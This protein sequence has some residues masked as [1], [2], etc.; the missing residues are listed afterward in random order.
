MNFIL[1]ALCLSLTLDGVLSECPNINDIPV[2]NA[3][4]DR[5]FCAWFWQDKGNPEPIDSCNGGNGP[6]MD[7]Y[8]FDSPSGSYMPMES[9][10]VKAGCTL[11]GYEGHA[12]TKDL[13]KFY[14]PATYPEPCT[15]GECAH[16]LGPIFGLRGF[17]SYRC[18]C[19]QDPIICQPTDTW[20]TIMQC[21][22]TQSSTV[23]KCTYS[24]TIGTTWSAS[25]T[26]SFSIDAS[27]EAAM[28]AS[29]WRDFEATLSVTG[30]T[31][32][33]WSHMSS[34]SQSEAETFQVSVNVP[35]YT[36]LQ[37]QGAEGNCG[38]ENVKTELFKTITVDQ[39]GN[40]ISVK[41][42][43]FDPLTGVVELLDDVKES[44]VDTQPKLMPLRQ[45][46]EI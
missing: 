27:I 37:I 19:E 33:D 32:Y 11:Y 6:V 28:K 35:P 39:E 12:F 10:I 34:E 17:A 45:T 42:E 21:D 22:N 31:G 20:N 16:H 1:V 3:A 9:I 40:E 14:G 46:N 36:L 13:I 2:L 29:F 26:N 43:K 18:R 7:D 15:G 25:T 8:D 38:G 5:F 30:T 41:V 24:K 4:G 44:N 23:A